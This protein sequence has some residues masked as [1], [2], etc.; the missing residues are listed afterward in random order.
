MREA[1]LPGRRRGLFF[2]K[3]E[4]AAGQPEMASADCDRARRDD[5]DLLAL[6]QAWRTSPPSS[7]SSAEPIFTT[8]RLASVSAAAAVGARK[9]ASITPTPTGKA[10]S[11]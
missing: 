1:D 10:H 3:P 8:S 9:A 6:S 4:G 7:T 5:D 11:R 2:L